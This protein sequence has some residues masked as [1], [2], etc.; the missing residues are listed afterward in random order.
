MRGV[1]GAAPRA[2]LR[3]GIQIDL[4]I[5]VWKYDR[6]DVTAFHDDAAAG[7]EGALAGNEHTA[8]ARMARHRRR[9]LV[10]LGRANRGPHVFSVDRDAAVLEIE[11]GAFPERGD[12]GLVGE[13]DPV[14]P[15]FPRQ[16][17]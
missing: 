9:G 8:Y 4:H 13:I 14:G 16:R 17:A 3:R 15:R 6:A 1:G 5:G 7:A 11:C 10:D 12:G 2:L